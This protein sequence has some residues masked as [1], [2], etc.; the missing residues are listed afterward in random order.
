MEISN[1]PLKQEI[2]YSNFDIMNH[3]TS[4]STVKTYPQEPGSYHL[5]IF[6]R[7]RVFYNPLTTIQYQ[8]LT[9]LFLVSQ[10]YQKNIVIKL[11]IV[12]KY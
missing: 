8:N 4:N 3:L 9:K 2:S 6:S 10:E 5:K 12:V 7:L 1:T 11:K